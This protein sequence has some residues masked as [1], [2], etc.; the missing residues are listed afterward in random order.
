MPS[1]AWAL[2]LA[3]ALQASPP[4]GSPADAW[5]DDRPFARLAPNLLDDVRALARPETGLLLAGGVTGAIVMHPADDDVA[6]WAREGGASGL[7]DVGRV[8]GDGWTQGGVAVGAYVVGRA[9]GHRELTHVGSDLV[10]AQVLNALITRSAKIV[11]GRRRPSG[12]RHAMPS[13]HASATFTTASVLHAHY[14]WE[15]GAPAYAAAAFVGWSSIRNEAHWVSDVIVGATIGTI[16][17]HTV[18]RGHRLRD[19]SLVPVRTDGGVAV[20]VVRD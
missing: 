16:V 4:A 12:G 10:R 20:F 18:T 3:A 15:V 19:W 8:L 6:D 5:P 11:G 14:G 2:A 17:G 9:T 1:V 13:G 7:A